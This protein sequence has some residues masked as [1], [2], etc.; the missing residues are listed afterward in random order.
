MIRNFDET[1]IECLGRI[2]YESSETQKNE[3]PELQARL[4]KLEGVKDALMAAGAVD[5]LVDVYKDIAKAKDAVANA[6]KIAV[7]PTTELK[8]VFAGS[9][10]EQRVALKRVI[11]KVVVNRVKNTASIKVHLTNGHKR[12]FGINI[13]VKK[14]SGV[15]IIFSVSATESFLS[16][17]KTINK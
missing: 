16:E 14:Q 5:A 4:A 3:L 12:V 6:Q 10:D 17:L 8:D 11:S 15:N 2:T 9:V 13:G 7:V 1:L